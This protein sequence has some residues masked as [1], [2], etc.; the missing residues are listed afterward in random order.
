MTEH[1]EAVHLGV[2]LFV[3]HASPH[4]PQFFGS[5]V[6]FVSQPFAA[7]LSQFA[8]PATLQ[9][10]TAHTEALQTSFASFPVHA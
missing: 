10:E 3:L 4:P 7:L 9:S 6:M 5:S 1:C 2:A 8:V